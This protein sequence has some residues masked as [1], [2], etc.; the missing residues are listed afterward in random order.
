[1]IPSHFIPML[2]V[3]V[4]YA[5]TLL[6]QLCPTVKRC[7]GRDENYDLRMDTALV[8]VFETDNF[9]QPVPTGSID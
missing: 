3:L 8:R 9:W 4:Y 2:L 5:D 1:M 6:Q 7:L